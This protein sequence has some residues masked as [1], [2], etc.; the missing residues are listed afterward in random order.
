MNRRKLR[1]ALDYLGESRAMILLSAFCALITAVGSLAAPAL[2]GRAID[3]MAPGMAGLGSLALI[4]GALAGVYLVSNLFQWFLSL[5]TNRISYLTARNLRRAL[6]EKL[7]SLPL[8]FFDGTAQGDTIS[9]FVNDVDAVS[10]GLLQILAQALSGVASI[11]G[12]A[13]FML[14]LS[15]LM[16][17]VVIVLTPMSVFTARFI[18]KNAQRRFREQ[19]EIVGDLNGYAE[20]IIEGRREVKAFCLEESSYARFAEMN[21]KLYTAGAA[22]QFYS[23][24]ANPS[25]RI[26]NNITYTVVGVAGSLIAI[27]GGLT[28][29]GISSFL[30]YATLFAKPFNDITN[31]L[32]QLQA[33]LASGRRIFRTLELPPETPD[34]KDASEPDAQGRIRFEGVSFSYDPG[35][36]LIEG[37]DLDIPYG[38]SVAI[39]GRTG[40]GK[41]TLV[42]LLMRFYDVNDGRIT[43]GGKD[44]RD[45]RR[46]D[47]RR[48][49]GMVL[50]DTWLFSGSLRDNIAYSKP[51]ASE[52]EIVAAA[53]EAGAD[54]FIV[55]MPRGYDTIVGA[56]GEGLS[57]GQRQ[58]I[59]IARVMLADPPLFILD[60]ATSSID[61]RTELRVQEA[62]KRLTAGRSN[63]VIAH[64]LSTIRGAD[65][66]LVLED[67][68]IVEA[69]S[70]DDLVERGGSYARLYAS[71]LETESI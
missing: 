49:F 27:A 33:A 25:T 8:S 68:R 13:V 61:T 71:R 14:C 34:R 40:A 59:T 42:N 62:L 2:I 65:L 10:D 69:G 6:F 60:E 52:E 19:A 37:L 70:H 55:R 56:S 44:I 5:I 18:A 50:Q 57:Q 30:I 46:D 24:L 26:V 54:D 43:L 39:V 23:S 22:A 11:V 17:L 9:R 48:C 47:L 31:V 53:R 58:L 66:I 21:A 64:R 63:F 36:R 1:K 51:G 45:F 67:G 3:R 35:R 16:A 28:V 7:S 12:A 20:E 38:R 4:L 29:G 41:T 32:T 15:P